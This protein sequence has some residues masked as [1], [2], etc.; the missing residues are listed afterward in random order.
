MNGL[1]VAAT[2]GIATISFLLTILE[3]SLES[4]RTIVFELISHWILA[5]GKDGLGCMREVGKRIEV[6]DGQEADRG[7]GTGWGVDRRIGEVVGVVVVVVA[8]ITTHA[9][10]A[11]G[12]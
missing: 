10:L 6:A 3:L 4:R 9:I 8:T 1:V 12:A 7:A 2:N 5:L 11:Q